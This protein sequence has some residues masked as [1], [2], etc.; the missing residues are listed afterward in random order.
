M[1]DRGR[2]R[3]EG[4]NLGSVVVRYY[5]KMKMQRVYPVVVTW[6]K[7]ER[8]SGSPVTLRLLMAGAQ[9]V[10]AEQSLST[11]DPDAE[12]TFYVTPLAKGGL[13]NEKLEIL[14][15]DR[16]V[17]EVPLPA[18]VVS[19]SFTKKLL[20][21]AILLPA[22]LLLF[23]KY[24]PASITDEE[25]HTELENRKRF[26]LQIEQAKARLDAAEDGK[27]EAIE[28]ERALAE[29][30]LH[31]TDKKIRELEHSPGKVLSFRIANEMPPMPKI[32]DDNVPI[33]KEYLIKFRDGVG[34][35]YQ[36]LCN[37]EQA[38]QPMALYVF[39]VL[40]FLALVSWW[41]NKSKRKKRW[42]KPIAA[43]RGEGAGM[44]SRRAEPVG[45]DADYD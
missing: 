23:C 3:S 27:K 7:R 32:V 13:R 33:V 12:A 39:G 10:P 8:R 15:G 14:V 1:A 42:S 21:L 28:K 38:R 22:F 26:K 9:V 34:D 31:D 2:G 29:K 19:Q 17:Q 5:K 16:K 25:L 37:F 18:R 6:G 4:G 44:S 40:V 41:F 11:N 20:W 30:H 36:E 43:P 24:L 35:V 45:A